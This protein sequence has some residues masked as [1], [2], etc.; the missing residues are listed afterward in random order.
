MLNYDKETFELI[1]NW[2]VIKDAKGLVTYLK[3]IWAWDNYIAIKG[4]KV[5]RVEIHTGGFSEH[6][7]I[8]KALPNMFWDIYFEKEI[9]GGHYYFKIK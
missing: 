9:K 3:S 7:A 5:W 8:I 6:E 4:K 1:K 2:D